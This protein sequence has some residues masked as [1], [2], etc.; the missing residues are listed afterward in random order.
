M[1]SRWWNHL[2]TALNTIIR[3]FF[4]FFEQR[5]L[6]KVTI[7]GNLAAILNFGRHIGFEKLISK[8]MDLQC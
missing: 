3:S 4:G 1:H 5:E 7:L 6:Q 2:T 8:S